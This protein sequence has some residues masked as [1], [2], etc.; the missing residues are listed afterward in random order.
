MAAPYKNTPLLIILEKLKFLN[1][2]HFAKIMTRR[3]KIVNLTNMI[4]LYP[5]LESKSG[6]CYLREL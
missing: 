1:Y 3:P 6:I 4:E 5:F 2:N